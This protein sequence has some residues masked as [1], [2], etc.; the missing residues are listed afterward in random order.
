VLGHERLLAWKLCH[1]LVLAVYRT[2]QGWPVHERYG[3]T[4]QIRRAVTS[5]PTNIAEGA[6]KHGSKEYRRYLDIALGSLAETAYLLMLARDLE[7]I[8]HV[9]WEAL[10][11]LRKRAGGLT[12]RL[13]RSLEKKIH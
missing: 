1:D 10:D 8:P 9:E 4:A 5:A 13:A 11:G 12:W 7:M 3:L 6:A 2:S